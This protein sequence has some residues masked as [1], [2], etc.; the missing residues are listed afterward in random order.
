MG[1]EI[2]I[3]EGVKIMSVNASKDNR[4]YFFDNLRGIAI[5][6][7]IIIHSVGIT[8]NFY[9]S[10]YPYKYN[11]YFG[12]IMRQIVTS[13]VPIF[14]F[15]SG[16][17]VSKKQVKTLKDYLSFLNNRLL[18]IIVPYLFWTFI[19]IVLKTVLTSYDITE[20]NIF[21]MILTG[22]IMPPY[23]FIIL[24]SQF[25]IIYPLLQYAKGKNLHLLI[26]LINLVSLIG[27]SYVKFANISPPNINLLITIWV[28]YF[29][30]GMIMD[31][32]PKPTKVIAV[33]LCTSFLLQL[34]ESFLLIKINV[35]HAFGTM[36]ITSFVYSISLILFLY[37]LKNKSVFLNKYSLLTRIG[38]VSFGIYFIHMFVQMVVDKVL[39]PIDV[40]FRFQPIYQII[41]IGIVFS[42]S[43]LSILLCKKILPEKVTQKLLGF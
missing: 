38:Q 27:M 43:Y 4:K 19:A 9:D 41:S 22:S 40:L 14:L 7:V 10:P 6:A 29:Y 25:Y 13:A 32:I 20:E 33:V 5:I 11:L 21:K 39:K 35:G 34:I 16:Y 17:W 1:L 2:L 18:R 24:I 30:M 28:Y 37:N 8:I 12:I 42:C 31:K 15:I 36:K 23:Y 26:F 3:R